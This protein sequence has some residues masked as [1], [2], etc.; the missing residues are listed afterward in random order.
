MNV[1]TDWSIITW[2]DA[3]VFDYLRLLQRMLGDEQVARKIIEIYWSR[4]PGQLEQVKE[5]AAADRQGELLRLV[6]TIK[7]SSGTVGAMQLFLLFKELERAAQRKEPLQALLK[8]IDKQV[9]E[10]EIV[11]RRALS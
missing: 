4:L 11:L 5:L 9:Q 8:T 6:H 3:P 1:D 10:F 2:Q 7:G